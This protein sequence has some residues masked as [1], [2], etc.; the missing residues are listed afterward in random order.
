VSPPDVD[1]FRSNS[2]SPFFCWQVSS[3]QYAMV[4][5]AGSK[6]KNRRFQFFTNPLAC[7]SNQPRWARTRMELC[8]ELLCST[9]CL[10]DDSYRARALESLR[11]P[12]LLLD[13]VLEDDLVVE[14][15]RGGRG[16]SSS[17]SK[18]SSS[19]SCKLK[20]ISSVST[21]DGHCVY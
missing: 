8:C 9:A 13:A 2:T 20:D 19:S 11:P 3:C 5:V 12:C 16:G 21:A 15:W 10:T 14:D 18:R 1:P 17:P 4:E 7:F 6:V